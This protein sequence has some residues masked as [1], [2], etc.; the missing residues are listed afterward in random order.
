MPGGWPDQIP[1]SR[2]EKG[3]LH[4]GD[5]AVVVALCLGDQFIGAAVPV[6][7]GSG[8]ADQV[9]VVHLEQHRLQEWGLGSCHA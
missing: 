5:E 1:E 2:D 6:A 9:A 8:V 7:G 4:L 3:R